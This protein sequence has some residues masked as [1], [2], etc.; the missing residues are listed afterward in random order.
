M[1]RVSFFFLQRNE[2]AAV[3]RKIGW[4]N[5]LGICIQ[6]NSTTSQIPSFSTHN[7]LKNMAKVANDLIRFIELVC[8]WRSAQR[9]VSEKCDFKLVCLLTTRT[10]G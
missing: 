6:I 1:F 4:N 9:K 7:H 5:V 2:G 10:T 3:E 8:L